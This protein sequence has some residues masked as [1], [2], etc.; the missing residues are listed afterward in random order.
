MIV[1]LD[2]NCIIYL[3]ESN[4]TWGPIIVS[5]L[6]AL[7]SAGDDIAVSDLA[8]TECLIGPLANLDS[9]LLAD[10]QTFFSSPNIQVLPLTSSVCERAAQIRVASKMKLKVPDCLHLASAIEHGCGMFLTN[11][12]QLLLC[13]D[14]KVELLI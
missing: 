11:D 10:Y 9:A 14:I 8:R 6:A 2:A 7:R 4:P 5:K 13:A 1:C 12:A 3:V